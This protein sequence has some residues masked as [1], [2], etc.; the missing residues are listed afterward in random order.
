LDDRQTSISIILG[1]EFGEKPLLPGTSTERQLL[2]DNVAQ[3]GIIV[4][5][6]SQ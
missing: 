2:G 1:F 4:N 5:I 3:F 6:E